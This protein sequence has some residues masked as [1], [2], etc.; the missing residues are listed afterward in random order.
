[1]GHSISAYYD[2]AP[3][4]QSDAAVYLLT[5]SAPLPGSD[6]RL[7]VTGLKSDSNV[8]TIGSTGVIGKG[9]SITLNANAPLP[10]LGNYSQSLQAGFA[11]KDFLDQITVTGQSDNAPITYYPLSLTYNG[12]YRGDADLISLSSALNF[13]FRGLGSPREAYDAKRYRALSNFLYLRSSVSWQ[14][15][16]PF[17][18]QLY[19]EADGQ[20][21]TG[22]LISNE[23]F[24]AGGEG[25]VRGYLQA[26]ALGDNGVH[27]TIELR[28]PSL[29]PY[30][31]KASV[32]LDEFRFIAF[33]DMARAWLVDP[34]P[35]QQSDYRLFGAGLGIRARLKW[36]SLEGDWARP[37]ISNSVSAANENRFYFRVYTQ[38]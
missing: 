33:A 2:V 11:Y 31:D 7:S 23:Q 17:G 14:R 37:F 30:V 22:P 24:A 5:Y 21:S 16:L 9:H 13:S 36:V 32:V 1:M 15:D 4:A 26:E 38:F 28:S 10:M 34:L 6:I 29:A 25:S 3:E 12:S 27:E 20:I 18:S 35:E 8:T 19:L